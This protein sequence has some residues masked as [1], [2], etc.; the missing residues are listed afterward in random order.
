[1]P[2]QSPIISGRFGPVNEITLEEVR[3]RIRGPNKKPP[4]TNS[5]NLLKQISSKQ[6]NLTPY[7]KINLF[8][9]I[10][11]QIKLDIDEFWRGVNVSKDKLVL[12]GENLIGIYEYILVKCQIRDLQ[13]HIQLCSEFSTSFL[14][15][16]KFGYCLA[17]IQM[18]M[19]MLT[20]KNDRI[21]VRVIDDDDDDEE[22]EE[23]WRSRQ[24]SLSVSIHEV[25]MMVTQQDTSFKL[26]V[27]EN[28][29]SN[30]LESVAEAKRK[31]ASNNF[32]PLNF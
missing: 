22:D 24:K 13:A 7:Q 31:R 5:I 11:T 8:A 25:A 1:M 21:D 19:T 2:N 14:K 20:E 26:G 18:A 17:T 15:T 29:L 9:K 12:D 4:F 16:T 3:R 10:S 6:K 28:I 32:N 30:K 23:N 27:P